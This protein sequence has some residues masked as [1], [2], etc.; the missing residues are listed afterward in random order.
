MYLLT[1]RDRVV[2]KQEL[3]EQV[4][5]EQFI[6]DAT[7]E[8]TI[9]EVRRVLGSSG[10]TQQ[11]IQ[12]LR[13][14]GY[15][16]VAPVEMVDT[17]P[18]TPVTAV[19]SQTGRPP[20]TAPAAAPET[21]SPAPAFADS[22]A[23]PPLPK[24]PVSYTPPYLAEKILTSRSALEGERKQ[25]TVLFC[26]VVDSSWLA[27]QED[28][29]MLH[30][31]M[32]QVLRLMA[33]AVHRYEGTVNQYLGDGLMALFGAP[34]AL[35]DH[36]LRAVQAALTI[37]ETI[38]GY[39]PQFQHDYGI[40]V[41]VRTGV[42]TGLVV[43][44]RI[45]D[46]LRM[47][48]T[49]MGNTTHL[50]ARLQSMA[51]AGMILLSEATHRLVAGY[52][53]SESLGPVEVRGQRT[54]VIVYKVT[55]RR[56]WRSR[57]EIAA[58]RGLT[59]LVGRQQELA[60][61][62]DCLARVEA[63][64]GYVVGITGEAGIGKSRLFYEFHQ[65]L[66]RGRVS[67]LTGNCLAHAQA[68]PYV[69][70]LELL[71]TSLQI[72][73]G[74]NP[75]Q[76]G[77]KLRQSVHQLEPSLVGVLPFL[78]ALFGLPWANDA[79]RH[80]TPKDKRQQTFNAIRALTMASSRVRPHVIVFE[81]LHWI[82]QTSE[83]CLTALIDSLTSMPV[84]VLTTH[85]SGYT[86]P[87]ANKTYYTQISL[88]LLTTS[89]TAAMVEALLGS[90]E[91]PAGLLQ[92]IQEK[93]GGNPLF[94]EEVLHALLESG[95]LT[96][97]HGRLHWNE[98]TVVAFPTTIQDIM[99]ARIDRL[100]EP[101]KHTV[102]TAAVVGREFSLLLLSQVVDEA[103]AVETNLQ[104]LKQ[105]EL[106]YETRFFPEVEYRFKHA[107]IQDVAYH[108]LLLRRR[109]A[110]HGS[111]AQ[112]IEQFYPNPQEHTAILAYHYARSTHQ[113]KAVDYALLAGDQAA[114]LCA[115]AEATVYYTQ[116]LTT[117]RT[118]PASPGAQRAQID[119]ILKLAA[120]G[121]TR[122]DM[123]RDQHN[124]QEAQ[125]LA[126]ALH[127]TARLASVLYWRGRLLYALGD[128]PNALLYAQQSLAIADRLGGETLA[129]PPVNLI[130]R[131]HWL[132]T[133]Y[134]Q[135]AQ[136]LMRSAEQMQ[137]LGNTTEEATAVGFAGW[138]FGLLGEF[139]QAGVCVERGL[140]LAQELYN[141][142]AE[143]A[144]YMYRGAVHDQRGD[145]VQALADYGEAR[146]LAEPAG[147]IFRVYLVKCLEGRAYM[148]AGYPGLGRVML[149]DCIA[150]A[151][152]LQTTFVL[153]W[154]KAYLAACLL[155][156]GEYDTARSLCHEAIQQAETAEDKYGQFM[157]Y[158]TLA[159][160]LAHL[161][162]S[163]P[164][165]AE[166]AMQEA[167]RLQRESSTK[168]ELARSYMSYAWL[169]H[170]W[171]KDLCAK[172]YLSQA[173]ALF[174]QMGM[175]WDLAKAEQVWSSFV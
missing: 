131:V 15:R 35:E 79:L 12:T 129:A 134:T 103:V 112:A 71:R 149:E 102:Q 120:V 36:A 66:A 31:F 85:R 132:Q 114:Q 168:P 157:A 22:D 8:S 48:Y 155:T 99:Q 52:V 163:D 9:A 107:V 81:N 42:N 94:I 126:E 40:E 63:G 166:Q 159:E 30:Q 106:I 25:I 101:V 37:Q 72:E 89:E 164:S 39:A 28:P 145:W 138:A 33:E 97:D 41:R 29:E 119:A 55:G 170:S 108:S 78:E 167:I 117:A 56:R 62:H 95:L 38:S 173:M 160:T 18:P 73:D 75:Q 91:L 47:D 76:I 137:H 133:E 51:E 121:T 116:A 148:M 32:D 59:A 124:L 98:E 111:I 123:E 61:L 21:A 58:E 135:A 122:Q 87:W 43:V 171:R 26:D 110:L 17:A 80:L 142:F 7:L 5:L 10:R 141:P 147:D 156:F 136:M 23:A 57:L 27:Q 125:A 127:D 68:T 146:R 92:F 1:H 2:S 143:A 46:N 20:A 162:T 151:D 118:L 109:Q 16:F 172:D 69:P 13:G 93:A 158:R 82:D 139:E 169:L 65:S 84:L 50:A 86:A 83:E 161:E 90:R 153:A 64:H 150:L 128:M 45:G 70:F 6:S 19:E 11:L 88:D 100:A 96:H 24:D 115:N 14:R 152:Q 60:L 74:D 34:V 104:T 67:W 175:A 3:C 154:P 113:D 105:A 54:P 4:W 44:G 49:A 140:R 174:Q 130:G 53:Y 165:Q 144:A 77:E